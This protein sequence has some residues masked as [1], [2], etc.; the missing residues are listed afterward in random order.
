MRIRHLFVTGFAMFSMFF[1]AGNVVFP[2][3]VGTM[4]GDEVWMAIAGLLITAVG[5]PFLG[6]LAMVLYEGDYHA[7]FARIGKVPGYLIAFFLLI[8]L[9]PIG[10]VPRCIVLSYNTLKMYDP[11]LSIVFF[12]F[13]ACLFIYV[14]AAKKSRMIDMLGMVLSPILIVSLAAIIIKGLLVHPQGLVLGCGSLVMLTSG[15]VEGYN[16]M[17]LL[18]AFF[19]SGVI[20]SNLRHMGG[21]A[22]GKVL[23]RYA[24]QASVIGMTLLGLVYAGF[25]LIASFYSST[26]G[27][28]PAEVLLG[29]IAH[30][31]LGQAGG[32]FVSL[33]VVL[34]CLTTALALSA[35][36][37]D[38]LHTHAFFKVGSYRSSLLLTL[39]ITFIFANLKFAEI[40]SMLSPILVILYPVLVVLTII[41]ILHKTHGVSMIK[42][43]VLV[44]ALFSIMWYHASEIFDTLAAL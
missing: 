42:M 25:A 26:L 34:A 41:N 11:T 15:L 30:T 19:F 21:G 16:T 9:G 3:V 35:V 29:T 8:L 37:A 6:L 7:F 43:P 13:I 1:G 14:A 4:A 10:A 28:L 40:V 24:L 23:A 18:A 17:D 44:T 32:V 27:P 33:V 36:F 2:L 31:V 38:F 22:S 39:V 20:I 12:S 5:L